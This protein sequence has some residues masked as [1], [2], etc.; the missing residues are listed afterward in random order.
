MRQTGPPVDVLDGRVLAEVAMEL[1]VPMVD[2]MRVRGQPRSRTRSFWQSLNSAKKRLWL[3]LDEDDPR[4]NAMYI[5]SDLLR[6]PGL[7][8]PAGS[9]LGGDQ[10][11]MRG[12]GN[13]FVASADGFR[14][15][16]SRC[17]TT[18]IDN[19]VNP[20]DVKAGRDL[21][22]NGEHADPIQSPL[23]GCGSIVIRRA[24]DAPYSTIGVDVIGAVR[25]HIRIMPAR[26]PSCC[27]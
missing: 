5:T 26:L 24:H 20:Q 17:Q 11:Y 6:G 4:R 10:V 14:E 1:F 21:V 2:T 19:L 22:A 3:L 9:P 13:R 16:F 18:A 23:N 12:L 25:R 15:W 7:P 8:G 27:C